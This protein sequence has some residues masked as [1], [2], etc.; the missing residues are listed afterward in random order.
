MYSMWKHR[1][2]EKG[3]LPKERKKKEA[4]GVHDFKTTCCTTIVCS[5]TAS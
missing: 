4:E 2:E 3:A 1:E 5:Q